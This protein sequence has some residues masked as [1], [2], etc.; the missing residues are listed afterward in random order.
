MSSL[1]CFL[2]NSASKIAC[3]RKELIHENLV[4]DLIEIQKLLYEKVSSVLKVKYPGIQ[5]LSSWSVKKF[6]RK[7]IISSRLPASEKLP[8]VKSCYN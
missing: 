5:G 8:S 1:L 6:G 7:K 4:I 3:I 2:K